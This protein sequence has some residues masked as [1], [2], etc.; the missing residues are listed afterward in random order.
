MAT[1][2]A[3]IETW[4]YSTLSADSTLTASIGSNIFANE[5]DEDTDAAYPCVL[6]AYLAGEDLMI[7]SATRVWTET[8]YKIEVIVRDQPMLAAD[9]IYSRVDELLHRGAGTVAGDG[10]VYS[11]VRTQPRQLTETAEG[12][13]K[14]RYSGGLYR[15]YARPF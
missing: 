9:S 13:N 1:V 10:E 6:F 2:Q 3:V 4:L 5:V 7:Q 14:Y 12:G 15:I 8:L 11:C